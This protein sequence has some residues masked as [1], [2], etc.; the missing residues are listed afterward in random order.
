[1]IGISLRLG[2]VLPGGNCI[3]SS[4]G[5]SCASSTQNFVGCT[6]LLL[7]KENVMHLIKDF[8]DKMLYCNIKDI[9]LK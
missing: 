7:S 9:W 6:A 1:V 2:P 3:F 4:D 8:A 5:C